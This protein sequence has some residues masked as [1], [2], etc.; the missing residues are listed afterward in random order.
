MNMNAS[1]ASMWLGCA[2]LALGALSTGC[3]LDAGDD[4]A[5]EEV[6]GEGAAGEHVE[7]TV[8]LTVVRLGV[9]G[10]AF[11]AEFELAPDV[12]LEVR[13]TREFRP[14]ERADTGEDG[15]I[16][17]LVGAFDI[18]ASCGRPRLRRAATPYNRRQRAASSV[19]DG[20]RPMG[21]Y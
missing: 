1:Q 12:A 20:L 15:A 7:A 19:G 11:A 4:I 18:D 17:T 8:S 16:Q 9:G 2:V 21:N 3:A 10:E 6:V 13:R 5:S 14:A